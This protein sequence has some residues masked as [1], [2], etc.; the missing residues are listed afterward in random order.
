VVRFLRQC[1]AATLF[2]LD[3]LSL[4]TK[5]VF[6]FY[7]DRALYVFLV[8]NLHATDGHKETDGRARCV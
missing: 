4:H 5:L 2:D 3:E 7:V 6:I 1:N 8:K